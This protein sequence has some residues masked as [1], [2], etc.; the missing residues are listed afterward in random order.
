M[1]VLVVGSGGR[2]HAIVWKLK[3]SPLVDE[4]FCTPGNGGTAQIAENIY[5]PSEDTRAI[6]DF[7]KDNVIDLTVIGPEGPLVLGL[8]DLLAE[9][10]MKVFGP[11]QAA[12]QMEGSKIFAKRIME[13][14]NVPTA[15]SKIFTDYDEAAACVNESDFPLVIKADGLAAGKGV[16]IT[17]DMQEAL[18]ALK[19]CL[20]D[21]K[22]GLAGEQVLIEDFLEGEE[23]SLL[24]FVQGETVIPM[25][26]AQDYKRVYDGDMG[27][28]TGGMGS[29]SP[30]PSVGEE[31]A[32][33]IVKEIIKPV[34]AE[35][36]KQGIEY[37]GV[38]YGGIILTKD[39]PKVLEFNCRFGDPE[40]QAIL[41]RM[42]SDLFE[43]MLAVAEGRLKDIKKIDWKSE[44]CVSVVLASK[45][46]PG[47][48]EKGLLIEGA[49]EMSLKNGALL[50]H[51]G[52]ALESGRLVTNGGR[53]MNVTALG[54]DFADAR[55]LAYEAIK[56]ISFEG[57][58]YRKDIALRAV[59]YKE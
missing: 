45:G 47:D 50:F 56:E 12:A 52:T 32:K 54:S 46:Y 15:A 31:T 33:K 23:L 4:I 55:R 28:N 44:P 59:N 2:E 14:C 22:F 26:C 8:S 17:K 57:I 30:V 24:S 5:I 21:K 7:A 49:S 25:V 37:S 53:V 10:G 9:R 11:S 20:I 19:T 29:Y 3:E 42:K 39:G 34:V 41:P 6:A 58:F 13:A 48:Y 38:L 16:I 27:P 35:L 43:I 1:K 40:T 51:G 18:W 36:A